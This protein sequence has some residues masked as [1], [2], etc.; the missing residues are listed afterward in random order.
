VRELVLWTSQDRMS[1]HLLTR[2]LHVVSHCVY[3]L[4]ELLN[5]HAVRAPVVRPVNDAH[6]ARC[7]EY[8]VEL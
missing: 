1:S 7:S 6:V 3:T 5:L 8:L 4:I 2:L